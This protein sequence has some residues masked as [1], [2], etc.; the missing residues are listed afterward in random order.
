[1]RIFS[2]KMSW[3]LAMFS[4]IH[5]VQ[6]PSILLQFSGQICNHNGLN[7]DWLFLCTE[8]ST[9]NTEGSSWQPF[10]CIWYISPNVIG[11]VL[12]NFLP[13]QPSSGL[14]QTGI[15]DTTNPKCF[16]HVLPN[17]TNAWRNRTKRELDIFS[18]DQ[19]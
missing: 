7:H 4:D 3:S 8:Q 13:K 12:Y 10:E 19:K 6:I 9:D 11:R 16:Q 1:M 2:E 17:P 15:P 14:T 5:L 18:S